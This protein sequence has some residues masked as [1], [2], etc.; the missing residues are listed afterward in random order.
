MDFE[1]FSTTV[2]EKMDQCDILSKKV[3]QNRFHNIDDDQVIINMLQCFRSV[4]HIM[5]QNMHHLFY[6]PKVH[7]HHIVQ[8]WCK[9]LKQFHY[10]INNIGNNASINCYEK[11]AFHDMNEFIQTIHGFIL[12][13]RY[14]LVIVDFQLQLIFGQDISREILSY[15]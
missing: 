13:F 9:V 5:S 4:L 2:E 10:A 3:Q 8:Y 6:K 14:S 12:N 11:I 15:L 7:S 1:T